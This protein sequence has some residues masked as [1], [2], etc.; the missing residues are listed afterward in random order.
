MCKKASLTRSTLTNAA[1]AYGG[2]EVIVLAGAEA[3]NPSKQI[4][5]NVRLFVY[6]QLFFYIGGSLMIG[7]M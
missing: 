6:R 1:F 7:M 2:T 4:P 3:K 5:R